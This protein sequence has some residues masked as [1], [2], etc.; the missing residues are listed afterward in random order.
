MK[1]FAT[2]A[3]AVFLLLQPNV[4]NA[5]H[6]AKCLQT[7]LGWTSDGSRFAVHSAGCLG[8]GSAAV[9]VFDMITRRWSTLCTLS[10]GAP[11]ASQ[12]RCPSDPGRARGLP[13]VRALSLTR[14][15]ETQ[16]SRHGAMKVKARKLGDRFYF[17]LTLKRG[18][19]MMGKSRRI[20][21]HATLTKWQAKRVIWGLGGRF[22]LLKVSYTDGRGFLTHEFY[23]F[24]VKFAEVIRQGVTRDR[25][26]WTRGG[27]QVGVTVKSTSTLA[28][29]GPDAHRPRN[30]LDRKK[31]WC[32]GAPGEGIGQKVTYHFGGKPR[33]SGFE[34]KPGYH[35]RPHLWATHNRVR[36]LEILTSNKTKF[37]AVFPNRKSTVRV[38]LAKGAERVRWVSFSIKSVYPGS[39]TTSNDTCITMIRPF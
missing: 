20:A 30:L 4:G 26:V 24:L 35:F 23:G 31:A 12:A 34:I 19:E 25:T 6:K 18:S 7:L 14:A 38:P 9:R 16:G 22:V 33:I 29:G 1:A 11:A 13:S 10:P 21:F 3:A 8:R 15:G 17:E 2:T 36:K 39:S 28:A 5:S 37:V 32:E 27:R